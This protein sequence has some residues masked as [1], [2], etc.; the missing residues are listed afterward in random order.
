M[1]GKLPEV[2]GSQRHH[3]DD[4]NA[5][6]ALKKVHEGDSLLDD[7]TKDLGKIRK[8]S[9]FEGLLDRLSGSRD[10]LYSSVS[11]VSASSSDREG[12]G[13]P[14]PPRASGPGLFPAVASPAS[15]RAP[16]ATT[17]ARAVVS[18]PALR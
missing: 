4:A 14:T 3:K 10:R 9:H 1:L 6:S 17:P 18:F 12:V 5:A 16:A 15:A 11:S 13:A 2:L 8:T 7:L